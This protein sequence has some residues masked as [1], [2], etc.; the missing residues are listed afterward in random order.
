MIEPRLLNLI[1]GFFKL[2]FYITLAF[3]IGVIIYLGILYIIT[4]P[5]EEKIKEVHKRFSLLLIAVF[6]IFL[7]FTIPKLIGMFFRIEIKLT[8]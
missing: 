4:T 8:P 2:L 5:S 1:E 3:L 7:S 6:L